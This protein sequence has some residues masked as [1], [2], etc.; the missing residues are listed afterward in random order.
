METKLFHQSMKKR[1]KSS[2]NSKS[3]RALEQHQMQFRP[4]RPQMLLRTNRGYLA[5]HAVD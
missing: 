1:G 5:P 2:R 4:P 3:S